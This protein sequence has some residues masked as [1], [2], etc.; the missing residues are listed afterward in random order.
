MTIHMYVYGT[1]FLSMVK[2][3][4]IRTYENRCWNKVNQASICPRAGLEEEHGQPSIMTSALRRLRKDD[5]QFK[6]SLGYREKHCGKQI[7]SF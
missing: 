6:A 7:L 2:Q 1:R 3:I 4:C 5:I